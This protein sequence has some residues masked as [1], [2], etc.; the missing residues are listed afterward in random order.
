MSVKLMNAVWDSALNYRLKAVAL[1]YADRGDDDGNHIYPSVEYI[2]WKTGYSERSVQAIT[3]EL[4]QMGIL[5]HMG[6]GPFGTNYYQ[7]DVNALPKR[8]PWTG[9]NRGKRGAKSAPNAQ[10]GASVKRGAKSAPNTGAD[11]GADFADGGADQRDGNRVQNSAK[12]AR[13]SAPDPSENH[14][15]TINDP[16]TTAAMEEIVDCEN[17]GAAAGANMDLTEDLV[18]SD[19]ER[20]EPD[21]VVDALIELGVWPANA[22]MV[23]QVYERQTGE[24]LTLTDVLAWGLYLEHERQYG[25]RVGAGLVVKALMAGHKAGERWYEELARA[26]EWE[27]MYYA[28][29]EGEDGAEIN[30]NDD[31]PIVDDEDEMTRWWEMVV[32]DFN[33]TYRGKYDHL[34]TQASPVELMVDADDGNSVLVVACANAQV[35]DWMERLSERLEEALVRVAGRDVRLRLALAGEVM[36]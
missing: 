14:K 16:S 19:P 30:A 31:A 20:E 17:T 34:L 28:F 12:N 24:M 26:Q 4:E 18:E 11:E 3:R 33:F 15:G 9:K 1:A 2:A 6:R 13:Q 36:A 10:I 27:A 8:P 32:I 5:I 22:E 7:M 21:D 29:D 23:A 35:R 25:R